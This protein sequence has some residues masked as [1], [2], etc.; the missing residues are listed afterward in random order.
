[1]KPIIDDP[2]YASG[3]QL[4]AG[5]NMKGLDAWEFYGEYTWYRNSEKKTATNF[6]NI[7]DPLVAISA[8]LS[9][10]FALKY[11]TAD[12]L[13]QRPFYFGKKLTANFSTGLKALWMTYTTKAYFTDPI[14]FTF[15]SPSIIEGTLT[16]TSAYEKLSSWGLGPKFGFDTSWMLG[17]GLKFLTNLSV[18]IPYTRFTQKTTIER[19]RYWL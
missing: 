8:N 4:G 19:L 12:F 17:Y 10:Q 5:F 7:T 6:I 11:D 3:F 16:T 14:T 2:G 18:S 15:L 9:A 1:M 13:I